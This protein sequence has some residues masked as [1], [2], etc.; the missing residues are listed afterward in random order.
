VP[1]LRELL[2]CGGS[3]CL[4]ARSSELARLLREEVARAG[5]AERARVV[6]V[7]CLGLCARGP[8]VLVC[9]EGVLYGA[10]GEAEARRIVAE[11]LVSGHPVE[12]LE[13]RERDG[14]GGWRRGREIPFYARQVRLALR[15]CGLVDPESLEESV[16]REG[17]LALERALLEWSPEEV[18]AS[19]KRSGL[20]G[21]GGAGFPTGL[22]WEMVREAPAEEK[23]VVCNADESDPGAFGDRALIEGD[24]HSLIE[25]LA[26]AARVV[27]AHRGFVF[28]RAEYGLAVERLA[29]A[30]EEARRHGLL[31][32]GILGSD[33]R[34]DLELRLGGGAFVC[35]EETA[36]LQSLEGRR[37]VPR[38][39]PPFPAQ[40][41]LR[42]RPTL[43]NNVETL[44]NVPPILLRGAEWF[45]ALGAGSSR[46]TKVFALAGDVVHTGLVEV[47]MGIPLGDLVSPIGGGL[48]PGRSLKAF[49]PGGPTGACLPASA[50]GLTVDHESFHAAGATMGSGGL[51]VLDDTSCM[52]EL[53]R[54]YTEFLSEESCGKCPPCRVGTRVLLSLLESVGRG[55][56][57]EE[58]LETVEELGRHLGANSLC[59][60][61]QNAANPALSTLR[62]FR[63]EYESH[64]L[65]RRCPASRCPALLTYTI[66]EELCDGCA[67]C[68]EACEASALLGRLHHVHRI[69]QDLCVHCG[70][71]LRVCPP[72]AVRAE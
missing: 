38:P 56:G 30:L 42:G 68:A 63:E 24:P 26:I 55:E 58:T 33:F 5:L 57:G 60:L 32:E 3:G 61:G 45:R 8:L 53:A 71:C 44:A 39:R 28:L 13:V 62:H 6:P 21:R 4:A 17:Y 52:V 51:I 41:G 29:G 70:A 22:K 25:A 49:Q 47:P 72:G 14:S 69:D 12:E 35:G 40:R 65:R 54:F 18:L 50:A 15:N 7:G 31:G 37:G 2:V 10:V 36:L 1:G 67:L 59:G 43:I 16:A 11:H 64:L 9:P 48:R 19:L 34:F 66:D 46:G 23:Y 27:G 20:R